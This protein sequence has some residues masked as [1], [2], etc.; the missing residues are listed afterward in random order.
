MWYI[1]PSFDTVIFLL[2]N[3]CQNKSITQVCVCVCVSDHLQDFLVL[4]SLY[5]LQHHRPTCVCTHVCACVLVDGVR[6]AI[7]YR[8]TSCK[9]LCESA[10]ARDGKPPTTLSPYTSH[11]QHS[12][13]HQ[14]TAHTHTQYTTNTHTQYTTNTQHKVYTLHTL[15]SE[16]TRNDVIGI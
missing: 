12:M 10:H 4:A 14:P 5:H 6:V 11:Q 13:T 9:A 16:T 8:C 1:I 7:M 3:S 15:T 2:S